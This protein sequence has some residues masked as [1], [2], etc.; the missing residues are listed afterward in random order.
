MHAEYLKSIFDVKLRNRTVAAIVK[1]LRANKV[2]Y[3]TIAVTGVS[4]VTMG[5]MVAFHLKKRLAIVR[6]KSDTTHSWINVEHL[7][8]SRNK[9]K[10]HRYVIIDDLISS[11]DTVKNIASSIKKETGGKSE[12]VG[13]VLYNNGVRFLDKEYLSKYI[14]SEDNVFENNSSDKGKTVEV[15]YDFLK[16]VKVEVKDGIKLPIFFNSPW[17]IPDYPKPSYTEAS[18]YP[19]FKLWGLNPIAAPP[20]V[21]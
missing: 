9:G 15:S 14:Y 11:G 16:P 8:E 12:C 13:A 1:T 2:K 6:K 10:F 21:C 4:G 5:S 7:P 18:T 19:E 3:D 20:R 17:I